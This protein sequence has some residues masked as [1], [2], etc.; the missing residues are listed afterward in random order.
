MDFM[1]DLVN[2]AKKSTV[3][4]VSSLAALMVNQAKSLQTCMQQQLKHQQQTLAC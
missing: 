3:F 1:E 2:F 4:A